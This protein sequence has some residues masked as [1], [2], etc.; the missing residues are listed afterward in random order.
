MTENIEFMKRIYESSPNANTEAE[1]ADYRLKLLILESKNDH[2]RDLT[3]M[4]KGRKCK[5]GQRGTS[6]DFD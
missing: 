6:R 4:L 5:H 3:K 1:K 2:F